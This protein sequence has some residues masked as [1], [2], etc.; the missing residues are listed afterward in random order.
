M[1]RSSFASAFIIY[2]LYISGFRYVLWSY[3]HKFEFIFEVVLI[4]SV[5]HIQLMIS[6][7]LCSMCQLFLWDAIG[8]GR[9]MLKCL[10][11]VFAWTMWDDIMSHM[12]VIVLVWIIKSF[13]FA[14]KAF[15][16]EMP[17]GQLFLCFP[18]F[19]FIGALL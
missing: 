4:I 11:I 12:Y 5:L 19:L 8:D 16:M 18:F 10:G 2:I 17:S 9:N 13:I 15:V 3:L 7:K 14:S 1:K 6:M